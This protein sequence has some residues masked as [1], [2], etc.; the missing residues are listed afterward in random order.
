MKYHHDDVSDH[1]YKVDTRSRGYD[2]CKGLCVQC[3][4]QNTKQKQGVVGLYR[5]WTPW[6]E[7]L[8]CVGGFLIS[9]GAE[10]C[11]S[12]SDAPASTHRLVK[13]FMR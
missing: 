2:Y 3:M 11:V 9:S 1:Q 8:T 12:R 7:A 5:V 13:R 6:G 4:I 10:V